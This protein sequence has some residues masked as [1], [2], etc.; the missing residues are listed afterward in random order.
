MNCTNFNEENVFID[1]GGNKCQGLCSFVSKL[2]LDLSWK[3]FTF[4]PNPQINTLHLLQEKNLQHLNITPYTCAAWTEATTKSFKLLNNDEANALEGTI[5]AESHA[6]VYGAKEEVLIECIDFWKFLKSLGDKKNIYI[7]M[8]IEWSEYE[9]LKDMLAKGWP[10]N[11][12]E[13]WIE[14][15]GMGH[16]Q[17][18]EMSNNLIKEIEFNG[19]IVNR[20]F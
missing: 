9:V 16:R 8:D 4:E 1:L 6:Q 19:T 20:W 3:I 13:M 5:G 11:I 10:I 17:F 12:K 18:E 7:K 2:N 14:F 15:H